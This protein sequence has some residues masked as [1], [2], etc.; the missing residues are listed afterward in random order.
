MAS[1]GSIANS[2]APLTVTVAQIALLVR[3][4]LL[5]VVELVWWAQGRGLV[6]IVVMLVAA[7]SY[8]ALRSARVRAFVSRHPL[9]V[10]IDVIALLLVVAVVGVDTPFVLALGTSALVVGL[11]LAALPGLVVVSLLLAVHLVLLTARP[12]DESA[13]STF[14]VLVPAVVVTLWLLGLAIQRSGRAEAR[15]QSFLRDAMAVAAASQ[16]RGRIAREM[17]DT[18]AKSLQAMAFTASSLTT[19]LERHPEVAVT[20]ARELEA[21]CTDVIGQVRALMGELR[22][23]A[24]SLP[25][26]ESV[27]QVVDEWSSRCGCRVVTRLDSVDVTDSLVCYELLMGLR[28]ALENVRRHAGRCTTTV[29]LK[30]IG[31]RVVL[32]VD[33]DGVGSDPQ[34][35]AASPGRGHFGV[36]GMQERMAH[37]AGRLTH[38]SEPGGGTTVTM[39]VHRQGL[40]EKRREVA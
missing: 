30:A 5:L 19:H 36:L 23:P 4:F 18:V 12:L 26:S 9:V 40:V 32:T 20:R 15:A 14:V 33:D 17:H 34:H 28:E 1:D 27:G 6:A 11:L 31:D 37:V 13:V 29:T 24:A 10:L 8:L 7:S 3:L 21:D 39:S 38:R 16:E 25:F 22:A 35:V 2:T